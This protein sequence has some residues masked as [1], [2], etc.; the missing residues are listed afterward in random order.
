MQCPGQSRSRGALL[1]ARASQNPPWFQVLDAQTCALLPLI[2]LPTGFPDP[3]GL[4]RAS[5]SCL[6]GLSSLSDEWAGDT[7]DRTPTLPFPEG[8]LP[9]P[10]NVLAWTRV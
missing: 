4:L 8:A 6:C 3:Q 1:S 9:L 2:L 10:S 5:C 7:G